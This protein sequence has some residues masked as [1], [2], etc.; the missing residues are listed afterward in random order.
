MNKY[1]LLRLF[2]SLILICSFMFQLFS[3]ISSWHGFNITN[4]TYFLVNIINILIIWNRKPFFWYL[5]LLIFSLAIY[6]AI[7]FEV[8][9]RS[10]SSIPPTMST[11]PI[12][13]YFI[14]IHIP[15]QFCRII[16][17]LPYFLYSIFLILFLVDSR[18]RKYYNINFSF[19]DRS[20]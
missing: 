4:A 15:R 14:K 19:R 10:S 8:I 12:Y 16:W 6:H 9:D 18:I 13:H 2:I 5:G 20:I 3:I 1:L 17:N 7:E 11:S